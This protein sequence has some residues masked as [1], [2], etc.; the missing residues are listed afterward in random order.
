MGAAD[1]A[2]RGA[3]DSGARG[4]AAQAGVGLAAGLIAGLFGVG[5]GI[6][7]VPGLWWAARMEQRRAHGTS[8][9]AMVPL[10][11]AGVA[12]YV[13]GGHVD[14]PA[15]AALAAGALVGAWTGAG[16]LARVRPRTLTI[17]FVAALLL[18]AA[19]MLLGGAEPRADA[20]T[21][22]GVAVLAAVGL[23]SG[24]LAGLLGI[25]GGVIMVPVM[26]IAFGLPPVV[27]KGTSLAVI[28]PTALVGTWRN[29]R[30]RNVDLRAAVV[31]GLGGS[32]SA[33]VGGVLSARLPDALA[34][35]LFGL[36]LL[37]ISARMLR[38][39]RAPAST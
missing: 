13:V 3:A 30:A 19:R 2:A 24:V 10:T 27:A 7:I 37:A 36:L 11:V 14:W 15:A 29:V 34:N 25:G 38:T 18:S 9:A 17:A 8:L 20:V 23:L 32:A 1:P 12:T 21:P 35:A 22:L 39:L 6:L 31:V 16:L 5:G 26:T 4:A 28:V 33:A